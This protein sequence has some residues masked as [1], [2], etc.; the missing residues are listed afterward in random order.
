MPL[1]LDSS[2]KV[3][4]TG[5]IAFGDIHTLHGNQVQPAF[6]WVDHMG[7][8]V[9]DALTQTQN[10]G[11]SRV[12]GVAHAAPVFV[13]FHQKL[14]TLA[15]T[16]D[17]VYRAV[18]SG[19]PIV[20]W[21]HVENGPAMRRIAYGEKYY[22][23]EYFDNLFYETGNP[24]DP[25]E[26]TYD[27]I[28][29]DRIPGT[30]QYW[31]DQGFT[32]FFQKQ[33]FGGTDVT[34]PSAFELSWDV[35]N[36]GFSF[37]GTYSGDEDTARRAGTY[38]GR[39]TLRIEHG[40]IPE[41]FLDGRAVRTGVNYGTS[42]IG[43]LGSI[44]NVDLGMQQFVQVM[45]I[46][47]RMQISV[48]GIG[49]PIVVHLERIWHASITGIPRNN[50][51]EPLSQ[52]AYVPKGFA[53]RLPKGNSLTTPIRMY[54]WT[55]GQHPRIGT[56]TAN[57]DIIQR[58]DAGTCP[59]IVASLR[60]DNYDVIKLA[61]GQTITADKEIGILEPLI[62]C[63]R[64]YSVR[65][66]QF[67]FSV[68]P[69]RF[70]QSCS[71]RSIQQNLGFTPNDAYPPVYD[72][73]FHGDIIRSLAAGSSTTMPSNGNCTIQV[74]DLR[75]TG[76]QLSQYE[77][78]MTQAP[79][80]T[81][82]YAGQ[83]TVRV[84]A[85]IERVS[86]R[87]PGIT[88]Y[89]EPTQAAY[90]AFEVGGPRN[91]VAE[92]ITVVRE[93]T[94]FDFGSMRIY[95]NLSV[96]FN[97]FDGINALAQ[98]TNDTVRGAGN[99]ALAWRWGY[100]HSD[101]IVGQEGE[102]W[103]S[104]PGSPTY[105][106]GWSRFYGFC[107]TYG[108]SGVSGKH[109]MVMACKGMGAR[110]DDTVFHAP[111]NMDGWN[112]YRAVYTLLSMAGIPDAR[113]NFMDEVPS[114]PFSLEPT[115]PD[116]A[117]G[118]YFLPVGVGSNPWTPIA[119]S[120]TIGQLLAMI[121]QLTQFVLYVDA[122]GKW[123][124]EPFLRTTTGIGPL[125]V[126]REYY[127]YDANQGLTQMWDVSVTVS[128]ADTRNEIILVGIDAYNPVSFLDPIL[129]SKRDELSISA[130]PAQQPVNYIG[131]K[132]NFSMVDSRFATSD[133]AR[134][135]AEKLYKTMRQP[136]VMVSFSCWG[137][138]DLF[139]MDMI[140]VEYTRSG[141]NSQFPAVLL[142]DNPSNNTIPLF[143]TKVTTDL[144]RTGTGK[145]T[146]TTRVEARYIPLDE[147]GDLASGVSTIGRTNATAT[148]TQDT[149]VLTGSGTVTN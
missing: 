133:Y 100:K 94:M 105:G 112:H 141:I 46:G 111:P 55:A 53:K 37:G 147:W 57:I 15:M 146:P 3:E 17:G 21:S 74:N 51:N 48:S 71:Y 142:Q 91:D 82:S 121:Q 38:G 49:I 64:V 127:A 30:A 122:L 115:D 99:I 16:D 137:Q 143:V 108:Y 136:S 9:M 126:F 32:A 72:V 80:A 90:E 70:Q 41:L 123:N 104:D 95:Q 7:G 78:T 47:G 67:S 56:N 139:P 10:L 50:N 140:G 76:S 28:Y 11:L 14:T 58:W 148:K 73:H 52:Y 43:M 117:T 98:R 13:P 54:S 77:L 20:R 107:D 63:V 149:Q 1:P 130:L 110:L 31:N 79:V 35:Y 144:T 116:Y 125:R 4:V 118:G 22:G 84:T 81:I 69:M 25:W 60:D 113:I 68:H 109:Q 36:A 135:T 8:T 5:T 65:N 59:D 93:E 24:S 34:S 89:V 83:T 101:G 129:S 120:M 124:Y 119:R 86:V 128:N 97:N 12:I 145:L 44:G 45:I 132:K 96:T 62:K 114:D 6:V 61:S 42:P 85:G 39:F 33:Q 26:A 131:W 92:Y 23:F 2:G 75:L 87:F 18:R 134:K 138:P 40:K 106:P 29:W 66:S 19:L 88:S 102:E 27:T 103:W